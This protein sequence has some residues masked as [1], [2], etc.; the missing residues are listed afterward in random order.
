MDLEYIERL[1]TKF[2]KLVAVVYKDI[3][4]SKKSN[5]ENLNF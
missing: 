5:I 3:H 4:D 1:H 2:G